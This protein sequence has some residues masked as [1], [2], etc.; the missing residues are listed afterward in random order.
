M[1][2]LGSNRI[3]R[4]SA[5]LAF[6]C[7]LCTRNFAFSSGDF[8]CAILMRM[9]V[10]AVYPHPVGPPRNTAW[11]YTLS[12]HA[13]YD[14]S[15]LPVTYPRSSYVGIGMSLY[16][17]APDM[18][19]I[20]T[21]STWNSSSMLTSPV[22]ITNG[23]RL[24][25]RSITASVKFMMHTPSGRRHLRSIA[26]YSLSGLFRPPNSFTMHCITRTGSFMR[27]TITSFCDALTF[28]LPFNR[29]N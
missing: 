17:F 25:L 12:A 8:I 19:K 20:G 15:A 26:M 28:R 16:P 1:P 2:Y 24:S 4:E 11:L 9:F 23:S 3:D 7:A 29:N 14:G 6:S 10:S 27:R 21:W 22:T 13:T 18:L 5:N